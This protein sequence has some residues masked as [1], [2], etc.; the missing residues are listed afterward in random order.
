MGIHI[1]KPSNVGNCG[2][3]EETSRNVLFDCQAQCL[4]Q[5]SRSLEVGEEGVDRQD[6]IYEESW[7]SLKV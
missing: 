6:D 3:A 2:D 5:D 4:Q 1:W 7:G